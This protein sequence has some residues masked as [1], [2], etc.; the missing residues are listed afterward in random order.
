MGLRDRSAAVSSKIVMIDVTDA[1]FETEVLERSRTTPVV[2]DLW[3]PWCGPCRQL[4]PILADAVDATDGD[5]VLAKVDID[6]NPA[7]AN[8][9]KVQSIPAVFAMKDAKVVDAFLGA[10]PAAEVGAFVQKLRPTSSDRE[11]AELLARG[12][13]S[14]LRRVLEVVPDHVEATTALAELLI[15]D[16]RNDEALELLGHLPETAEV[17]RIAAL[18]RVGGDE[19]AADDVTGRLT[20]LLARVADDDAARQEYLDV[21]ELLG[22]DDPRTNRFRKELSAALF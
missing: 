11:L 17:R 16:S 2:I 18:A 8:A 12:D 5:V 13:E 19:V 3:A 15:G 22:P 1:T 4:G 9:F 7:V 21:L 20:D 10:R 14:S 6:D